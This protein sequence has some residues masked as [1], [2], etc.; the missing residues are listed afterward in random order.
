MIITLDFETHYS[1]EYG[2]KKLTTEHYVRDPRF[3]VIGVGVALG[4]KPSVWM[5]EADFRVWASRVPWADVDLLAHHAHFD[6][7]VLS[8]HYGVHPRRWFDTLSMGRV[9]HGVDVGGSLAALAAHYGIGAKGDE[10]VKALGKRRH[11]FTREEWLAYGV[12]C[13]NDVELTRT[14][15]Q[16]MLPRIPAAELALIDMT[17]RM[18]TRP[19]FVANRA[20]LQ[21]ALDEERSRKEAVLANIRE[22]TGEG[23]PRAVLGS[24]PQFCDLLR[25]LGVEPPMKP[26]E[27]GVLIPALA[28]T[29]PGMQALLEAVDPT[30]RAVAVA[31]LE[32]KSTII[33]SRA[34]RMIGIAS[35]GAV[36]IYLK[37]SGAHT[38]RWSGGDKMNPQNFNRGGALRAALEAPPGHVLAVAD[39]GQIEA[40]VVGW[41]A[42]EKPLLETFRRN[43]AIEDGDFYSDIGGQFFGRKLSKKDT[44]VERQVSKSMVLGLGFG[45]GWAKFAGEL[46]KGMLG[47][48][49]VQFGTREVEQFR[50]DVQGFASRPYGIDGRTCGDVVAEIIARIPRDELLVHCAVTDHFVRLYRSRNPRIAAMWKSCENVL[51]V[52]AQP[53]RAEPMRFGCLLVDHESITKPSGLVMRYPKLTRRKDGWAYQDGREWKKA[54]GGLLTENIVQSLARDVVAEQALRIQ[55]AG[56]HVATTTHDEVVCIVPEAQGEECLRV[57]LDAMRTPPAWC[58]DLP[59]NASGSVAISYGDAK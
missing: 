29:D 59:L 4:S 6:G 38:H 2:L 11:Q 10:V 55:R 39:S 34:E 41:V 18:F 8:H 13:N 33:E 1:S 12:Y 53:P 58:T 44:P 40:R 52:M 48:P 45:M 7:L 23:D 28:K 46:L 50:V 19:R 16:R 24:A 31:R 49:P 42:G 9:L 14:L 22:V 32:V 26:N 56:Y 17:V 57:M 20:V 3:Q 36:P 5:E 47:A 35:R 15:F 25:R 54:Y 43:D 30:V 21:Q 27:K 51:Q 37:Y